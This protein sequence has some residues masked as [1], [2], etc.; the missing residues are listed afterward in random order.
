MYFTNLNGMIRPL[1]GADAAGKLSRKLKTYTTKSQLLAVDEV[2][3]PPPS[4][5]QAALQANSCAISCEVSEFLR[6]ILFDYSSLSALIGS[7]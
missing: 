7:T 4:N 2:G 1:A 5:P 6:Q 3:R